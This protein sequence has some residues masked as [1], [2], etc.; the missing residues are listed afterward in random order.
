MIQKLANRKYYCVAEIPESQQELASSSCR[1]CQ[2]LA[3]LKSDDSR[4]FL[5]ALSA[6]WLFKGLTATRL[7]K[8]KLTDTVL[9][10]L[11]SRKEKKETKIDKVMGSLIA[12]EPTKSTS[13]P[14][15]SLLPSQPWPRTIKYEQI[16]SWI[17]YC[18]ENHDDTCTSKEKTQL[19]P[20]KAINCISYQSGEPIKPVSLPTN[21][22]YAALS[23]V[24]GE[25]DKKQSGVGES[26]APVI[27]DS[28]EVTKRLGYKYLWVDRHCIDQKQSE[29]SKKKE[30]EMMD[31]IYS[32]A[33]FTI[34]AAAGRDSR[35]GLAGVTAPRDQQKRPLQIDNM[36]FR[37]LGKPPREKIQSTKWAERGWT[38]QEGFLSRR[39][40]FF[41]NEQFVFQCNNMTCLESLS[42]SMEALHIKSGRVLDDIQ[43]LEIKPPDTSRKT[44]GDHIMGYSAKQ[45]TKKEDSLDAFLGILS[46]Y[47]AKYSW[48]QFLGNPIHD[49]EPH[50][51]NAWYHL[52]PATRVR[53]FPTWSWTGWRG[54]LKLTSRDNPEY[55]L[56]LA[57][58]TGEIIHIDVYE[59]R[60]LSERPKLKPFI[61]LTGMVIDV[62]FEFIDWD[63]HKEDWTQDLQNGIWAALRFTDNITAYSLFYLDHESL[64]E[65]KDF[66]LPAMILESGTSSK[67]KNTIIL[68]LQEVNGYYQRAGLIRMASVTSPEAKDSGRENDVQP[69]VYKDASGCW[70]RHAPT[71]EMKKWVWL[72]AAKDRT[73]QVW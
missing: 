13:E 10:R 59:K 14:F 55:K 40:I 52:K 38:Y 47:E 24:W 5:H 44:I 71:C 20:F 70:S 42:I 23:Y 67:E 29:N 36:Q 19:Q 64:A 35:D 48:G 11:D 30:F 3:I 18:N 61:Q 49:E 16:K 2:S 7:S 22:E 66:S 39:R 69:T 45:L 51:I 34:I 60:R 65:K 25:D 46:Y 37:Y 72:Q 68:V 6:G 57:T 31:K 15:S 26:T 9:L 56:E 27:N 4:T 58:L 12:V 17:T 21:Q 8:L 1:I 28:I 54:R 43:P 63:N 73:F 33:S 41:T 50:M 53:K 32:Q 62:S